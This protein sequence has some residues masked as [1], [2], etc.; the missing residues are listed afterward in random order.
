MQALPVNVM[1]HF[2]Y[3]AWSVQEDL[4]SGRMFSI[5]ASHSRSTPNPPQ[6]I[7]LDPNAQ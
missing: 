3:E 1:I 2:F 4:L 7:R 5:I 6:T